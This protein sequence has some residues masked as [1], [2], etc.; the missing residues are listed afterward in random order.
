MKIL[1]VDDET[2]ATSRLQRILNELGYEDITAFN[3]PLE[4]VKI[5]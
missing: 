3:D 2:L 1:I 4:V 5:L